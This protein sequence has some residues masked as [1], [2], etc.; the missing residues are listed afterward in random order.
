MLSSK[1]RLGAALGFAITLAAGLSLSASPAMASAKYC[2]EATS[3]V[4]GAECTY[5][6]GVGNQV[7]YMQGVFINGG[8]I[9][10]YRIHIELVGP[11]GAFIKNCKQVNVLAGTETPVCQWS[12]DGPEYFGSYCSRAWEELSANN[13]R[14]VAK[15]CVG[16]SE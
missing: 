4:A 16:V 10:I 9:T 15:A 1:V 8:Y 2:L 14:L 12:P 7:N 5:I 6:N 13:Y 11:N 3:G